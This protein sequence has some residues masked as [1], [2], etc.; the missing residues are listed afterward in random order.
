MKFWWVRERLKKCNEA[1]GFRRRLERTESRSSSE[2]VKGRLEMA[3]KRSR[4]RIRER[5][6]MSWDWG[7]LGIR[8]EKNRRQ[9]GRDFTGE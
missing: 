6:S 2:K 5:R 7:R 1:L 4:V 3:S 8:L 9:K